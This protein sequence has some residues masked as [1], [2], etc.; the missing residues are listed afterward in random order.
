MLYELKQKTVFQKKRER[1]TLTFHINIMLIDMININGMQTPCQTFMHAE[2]LN[3]ERVYA[4]VVAV[5]VRIGILVG[6]KFHR[7]W[8]IA[9]RFA[10]IVDQFQSLPVFCKASRY[11]DVY[12]LCQIKSTEDE[13][14]RCSYRSRCIFL[15]PR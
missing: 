4:V 6:V 1:S 12:H 11:S 8:E 3:V 7:I 13:I 2:H 9:Q 5:V 15:L 14:F 10:L